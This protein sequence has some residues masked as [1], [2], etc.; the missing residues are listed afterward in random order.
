MNDFYFKLNLLKCTQQT[1]I[2]Y[3]GV[4][5]HLEKPLKYYTKDTPKY[6]DP[7]INAGV[8]LNEKANSKMKWT[9]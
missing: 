7:L 8:M 9:A 5:Q 2:S 4:M 6:Y 1:L 3:V